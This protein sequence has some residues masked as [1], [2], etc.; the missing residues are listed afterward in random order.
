MIYDNEI[1]Y[2][3]HNFG[4]INTANILYVLN[5]I[6]K[7]ARLSIR[8]DQFHDFSKLINYLGLKAVAGFV[9]IQ[10]KMNDLG[11]SEWGTRYKRDINGQNK[12]YFYI[13]KELKL[14]EELRYFDES[15]DD[16]R[17]GLLLEYPK[18]CINSFLSVSN[19][20][21]PFFNIKQNGHFYSNLVNC[22]TFSFDAAYFEHIPCSFECQQTIEK[23]AKFKSL[24]IKKYS[25]INNY[26]EFHT[27]SSILYT[28]NHGLYLFKGAKFISGN[29]FLINK[30]FKYKSNSFLVEFISDNSTIECTEIGVLFNDSIL[31]KDE[32]RFLNYE[33][34]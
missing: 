31:I 24:L 8:N 33:E 34:N 22:S 16:L 32:Y 19:E 4:K 13:S 7:C 20:N 30:P 5:D 27:K 6:K 11:Y 26:I 10:G 23:A 3:I 18:C 9:D 28:K 2:G 1:L 15:S 17:V 29:K 12:V 25:T 14:I 21:D